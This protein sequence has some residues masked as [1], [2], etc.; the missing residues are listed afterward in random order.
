MILNKLCRLL[1]RFTKRCVTNDKAFK[2]PALTI[3]FALFG[4]NLASFATPLTAQDTSK[5]LRTK[6]TLIDAPQ[7]AV[8]NI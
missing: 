7:K 1:A 4:K 3:N 2:I 8:E 6:E 5:S